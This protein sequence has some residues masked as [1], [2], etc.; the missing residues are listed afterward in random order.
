MGARG[1][2]EASNRGEVGAV[3]DV[4]ER[5]AETQRVL[6]RLLTPLP[7]PPPLLGASIRG[8]ADQKCDHAR[9]GTRSLGHL[10]LDGDRFVVRQRSGLPPHLEAEELWRPESDEERAA[11]H[12]ALWDR[13]P[14]RPLYMQAAGELLG[15]P[16]CTAWLHGVPR[17]HLSLVMAWLQDFVHGRR[18]AYR[19]L[20]GA[21]VP[22]SE[23]EAWTSA[24]INR[25]LARDDLYCTDAD[26]D[27]G[28]IDRQR[29][30]EPQRLRRPR[31]KTAKDLLLV[32]RGVS[33]DPAHGHKRGGPFVAA[34]RK[35]LPIGV[36]VTDDHIRLRRRQL[37][38]GEWD[39]SDMSEI[40]Q[41]S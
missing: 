13:T 32:I 37:D 22:A 10:R 29:G 34:V 20:D 11:R 7:P 27:S 14:R 30:A 36:Q 40:S 31:T 8:V 5:V 28:G 25:L 39:L 15:I 41:I 38:R 16:S 17:R 19:R 3:D 35:K 18:H 24:Q 26:P 4:E 21:P 9:A 23:F 2:G 33:V 6:Q 1:G 12:Q